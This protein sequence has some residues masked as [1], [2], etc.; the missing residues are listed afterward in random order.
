M[1]LDASEAERLHGLLEQ[2]TDRRERARL[3]GLLQ[4]A[5]ADARATHSELTRRKMAAPT[6]KQR[7]REGM[8]RA[9]APELV[10]LRQ[11][12]RH[13]PASIRKKFLSEVA[14]IAEA[15]PGARGLS[16]GNVDASREASKAELSTQ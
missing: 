12:W 16:R 3:R 1:R 5:T 14:V 7:I 9:A 2:A 4:Y 10:A 15:P 6:V 8:A 13:A 11:A